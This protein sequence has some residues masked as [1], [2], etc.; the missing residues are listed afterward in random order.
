MKRII[1]TLVVGCFLSLFNP[2]LSKAQMP[3]VDFTAIMHSL[4]IGWDAFEAAQKN[5][6]AVQN[7]YESNKKYID[8]L[9]KVSRIA[10]TTMR[11]AECL[12][13][14]KDIL[15]ETTRSIL[16]LRQTNLFSSS[17]MVALVGLYS[18][19]SNEGVNIVKDV[20]DFSKDGVLSMDDGQRFE[21]I[22]DLYHR[23]RMLRNYSN[24]YSLRTAGWAR[25][26]AYDSGDPTHFEEL[27][28]I[29]NF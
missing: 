23:L 1:T 27:A 13:M 20:A 29:A 17:E 26:R 22:D 5:I 15:A 25:M 9:K 12:Q 11:G 4:Q 2:A 7:V 19:I 24:I 8:A 10:G 14:S 3:T 18:N 6:K 21:R 28:R 16:F